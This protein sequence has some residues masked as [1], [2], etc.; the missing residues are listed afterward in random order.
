MSVPIDR[1]KPMT[2][3]DLDLPAGYTDLLGE[4]KNRVRAARTQAIRTVNTQLIALY[5]SIGKTI[6]ERQA[7]EGPG[8]W[9][10]RKAGR[11]PGN[12]VPGHERPVTVEPAVHA[13]LR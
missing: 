7:A 1:I 8:E 4:L 3:R 6:L 9:G 12:G 13:Q 11:R 2:A 10:H 5:W